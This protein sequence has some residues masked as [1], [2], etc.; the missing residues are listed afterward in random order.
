MN[1]VSPVPSQR[2]AAPV[3]SHAG[4]AFVDGHIVPVAEARIP[5]LDL[6]FL[7]SDAC[8]DTI[9]VCNGMFFC[10]DQHLARFRRSC[11]LLKLDC[12]HDDRALASIMAQMVRQS[13]LNDAYVQMI[14]T[15]G[16]AASGSR[17]IRTCINRFSAFCIPYVHIA[18]NSGAD[19]LD[20]IVSSRP[21]INAASVP[22]DV[23]NYHWIDFELGLLEAY[24]RGGNTV[25]LGDGAG[26]VSEG[27]GFNIFAVRGGVLVTPDTNVLAG[28]TR[29][30]VFELAK[31]AGLPVERRPLPHEE[32]ASADEAFAVSTAGGVMPIRSVDG[33]VLSAAPGRITKSLT[34]EYW[35]RRA[36]GWHGTPI[37]TFLQPNGNSATA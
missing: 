31:D 19:P 11:G 33:R 9:S 15:R 20:V 3:E 37:A 29:G 1:L 16:L 30:V 18:P 13:G 23:K 2:S 34:D 12:P 32:F 21:R 10:L 22:S 7:R 6:G 25:V 35:R 4:V 8:Q 24:E 28:I 17:D 36:D 27:P 26:G 5:L 14:M